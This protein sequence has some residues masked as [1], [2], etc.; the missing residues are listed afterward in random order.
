MTCSATN[1]S[2]KNMYFIIISLVSNKG[3]DIDYMTKFELWAAAREFKTK[4]V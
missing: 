4:F 2:Q 1:I 3:I